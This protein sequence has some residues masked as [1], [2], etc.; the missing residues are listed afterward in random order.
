[1]VGEGQHI[2]YTSSTGIHVQFPQSP[3]QGLVGCRDPSGMLDTCNSAGSN[4]DVYQIQSA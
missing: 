1:M 2:Y 3:L 4:E